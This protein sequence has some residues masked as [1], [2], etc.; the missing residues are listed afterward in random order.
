MP[1]SPEQARI[2]GKKGG[3]KKGF[4]GIEAEKAREI[5]VTKLSASLVPIINKAIQQAKA[6]DKHARAWLFDRAYGRIAQAVEIQPASRLTI[7]DILDEIERENES[8]R[9]KTTSLK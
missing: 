5:F 8:K 2:N 4:A 9:S 1:I 3:R 7:S 6:G